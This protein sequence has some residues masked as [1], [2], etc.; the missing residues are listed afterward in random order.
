VTA[1]VI[2]GALVGLS[3]AGAKSPSGANEIH[4]CVANANGAVRFVSMRG[5]CANDE[6]SVVFNE[7]GV[8]GARGPRGRP[9]QG[10]PRVPQARQAL[11]D[12]RALQGRPAQAVQ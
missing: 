1:A 12:R 2:A 5:R 7:A 3:S 4:A 11:P 10:A 9:G 8:A 6:H